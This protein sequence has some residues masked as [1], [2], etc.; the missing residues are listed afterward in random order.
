MG[1]LFSL[2]FYLTPH[3]K[4]EYLS[5][6]MNKNHYRESNFIF[7]IV[8]PI[9]FS[10]SCSS[11]W[12]ADAS[13]FGYYR[14]QDNSEFSRYARTFLGTPYTY[15]GSSH[16]GM[17]CSGLVIR[18]FHDLYGIHLPHSTDA[19]YQ[20]GSSVSVRSLVVGD[21]VFFREARFQ[22]PSHVGIYLGNGQFIHASQSRGVIISN[23]N[24]KYYQRRFVGAKRIS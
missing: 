11:S 12:Y 1:M 6:V 21:L 16:S 18:I 15:G 8:L 19:L 10:F 13:R 4:N 3:I 24:E 17:D 5:G 7:Y 9:F 22:V 23:L 20:K 14:H 2:L